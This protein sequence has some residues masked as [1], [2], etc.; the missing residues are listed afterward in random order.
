MKVAALSP[1]FV[2][3]THASVDDQESERVGRELRRLRLNEA[4]APDASAP[5]DDGFEPKANV[6]AV[7]SETRDALKRLS[8]LVRQKKSLQTR[9][10]A[11]DENARREH[12][13]R[14]R[15]LEAY[16]T[17][18]RPYEE[19]RLKGTVLNRFY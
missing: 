11:D 9:D 15:A 2:I 18:A 16:R 7:D 4:T 6:H 12:R 19:A 5:S 13:K 8:Q 14:Q 10:Q 3:E 17:L 1:Q